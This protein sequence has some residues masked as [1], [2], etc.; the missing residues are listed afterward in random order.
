MPAYWTAGRIANAIHRRVLAPHGFT[1]RGRECERRAGRLRKTLTVHTR[2]DSAHPQV[3]LVAVVALDG[4]PERVTS[5]RCDSLGGTA[6]TP[7]ERHHYPLPHSADPLPPDLLA[8]AAGPILAFLTAADGLAEFALWAQ[9]VF[10]GQDHPGW[11]GRYRPVLP[12]GTAPL[13]AAAFAAALLRDQELV[14]FLT[15]RVE[16]EEPDEH[17]FDDYLT[18]IRQFYPHLCHRHPM[19]RPMR[20]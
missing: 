12:H 9:E 15:A 7:T 19:I 6:R 14:E 8:D 10:V 16:N 1:R 2:A 18:E 20:P 3:E 4:L 17:R 5:H 11:W 13:Q